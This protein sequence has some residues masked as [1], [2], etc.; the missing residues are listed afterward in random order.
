MGHKMIGRYSARGLKR[1]LMAGVGCGVFASAAMAQVTAPEPPLKMQTDYFGYA[2]SVSTRFTYTDNINLERNGLEDD[3]YIVSTMLSGGAIVSTP[4]V[5]AL[6][7]GDLDLGYMFD[8]EDFIVS[9]N[10]GATSTFTAVDN[11]LYLDVSGKTSRQLV[12]DN[13]RYSGNIAS[14]R[15][16]QANVHSY[17]ASPYIYHRMADQSAVEARYRFSQVF[18]D[19][20]DSLYNLFSGNFLNDSQSQE[21]FAS[22]ESGAKFDRVRFRIGAYGNKTDETGSGV[23]P[24]FEYKQ[25][26]VFGEAQFAVTDNFSLSGAAGYDEVETDQ[27]ASLF[28]NDDELSG[29][30]WR[31]GFT[32]RPN[33]RSRVRF[34]YGE[35]YGDG[36]IDADVFYELSKRLVFTA[37]ASRS[38]QTRAQGIN[39]QFRGAQVETL[40]FADRLREGA[41]LSPRA[42]IEAAN[43]FSNV[44]SGRATQTVGVAITDE[45][46]AGLTAVYDRTE[47]SLR[48][49]YSDSDFGFR[50]VESYGARFDVR[51]QLSRRLTAYAG[52]DYRHI[53]T[54]IST[55][56]CEAN[57]VIFGLDIADP[58]FDVVADCAD[59]AALNGVTNTVIGRLGASYKLYKNVSAFAEYSHSERFSPVSTLEYSENT[60]I[61]GVTLDF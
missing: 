59:V 19:D 58:M 60:G 41:E 53:D 6:I 7:L 30:F 3:E 38:F 33:R 15:G 2:A 42:V 35:R 11:W 4:R 29:A 18:V 54:V 34:E 25:G 14:A 45:A 46:Y 37:G 31:A 20:E 49:N 39:A 22:Y 47:F 43:R 13:A 24:E 55:D 36:F 50:Q 17:S 27:A 40:D 10:I 52:V 28:F 57:P 1:A 51:H 26:S 12:G 21:V 32:A 9:Q 56:V 48:G 8:S 61:I 44:L 23:L 5:T 16:Q